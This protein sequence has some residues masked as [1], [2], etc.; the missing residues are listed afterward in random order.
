MRCYAPRMASQRLLFLACM[1]GAFGSGWVVNAALSKET[2]ATPPS[3]ASTGSA[4]LRGSEE[5]ASPAQA[6]P[7]SSVSMQ[8]AFEDIYRR[9]IWGKNAD[10]AGNSGFGS[11]VRSTLM[12]RT[13]LQ[14]FM[15]D[16]DVHSVVDAGCGDWEFSQAIDWKGVDYK[17]FDIVASVIAEDT[18]RYGRPGIAFF[19]GNMVEQDLPP[20][21]LLI[22]KHVLQ[23]LPTEDVLKFLRQLPKYKHVLLTA[24]VNPGTLSGKNTDI[25]AGS[26]REIDL[27]RPP[28]NVRGAKVLTYWDG[29]NMQQVI[30]VARQP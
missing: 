5:D 19:A 14:Q 10:D 8:T 11:S 6:A 25:A 3:A 21:D 13:F 24:S 12:Y 15:K 29:G 2:P 16:A 23:H 4:A 27:T 7:S 20:A 28:F 26:F 1:V 9:A 30:Y 22:S 18:K 17:G